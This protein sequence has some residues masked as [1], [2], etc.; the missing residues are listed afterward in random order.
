MKKIYKTIYICILF[1]GL[2]TSLKAQCTFT[3]TVPYFQNFAGVTTVS[4]LPQCWSILGQAATTPTV[5]NPYAYFYFTPQGSNYFFTNGIQLNAGVVYSVS[6]FYK[7]DLFGNTNWSNLSVLL[8]TSQSTTG[9]VT[10]A[11]TPGPAVSSG[12]SPL[13][14]T[15]VTTTSGIYYVA[16]KGTSS[17]SGS[18]YLSWDDLAITIPCFLNPTFLN[19]N[20]TNTVLCTGQSAVLTAS[21]ASSY[22]W[23]TGATA[24]TISVTPNGNTNYVISG[25]NNI[26][27]V[28]TKSISIQVN[29]SPVA[30]VFSNKNA[31]CA[32]ES[33]TLF[34]FGGSAATLNTFSW[35]NGNTTN[36]TIVSP[37]ITS[38]YSVTITNSYNCSGSAIQQIIVNPLPTITATPSNT[39]ACVGDEVWITLAGSNSYTWQ[40]S[41]SL[42]TVVSANPVIIKQ[43][44]SNEILSI[45]G[46]NVFGCAK[47]I[48]LNLLVSE[49]AGLNEKSLEKRLYLFPNPTYD[50]INVIGLNNQSYIELLDL[51]G[52][53]VFTK[54]TT[55]RR[56]IIDLRG[57]DNG[58]YFLRIKSGDETVEKKIIK[59]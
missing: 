23:N 52:M 31:I 59:E 13:S 33:A 1:F 46:N 20:S 22:S 17:G 7:T 36:T 54:S 9:L 41:V 4:P 57:F 30:S 42:G 56:L 15:F 58:L 47:T 55:D 39:F 3:S 5:T 11:S 25:T 48:T 28:A 21:G 14:N 49:C 12:F 29:P 43:F 16:I 24:S 50:V 8:G 51:K 35:S 18:A 10:I 34:A 37:T 2:T 53:P 38:N 44:S 40:S 6:L 45:T 19:V 32:G 27:C 26:G